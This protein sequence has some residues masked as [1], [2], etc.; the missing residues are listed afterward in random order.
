MSTFDIN[1]KNDITLQLNRKEEGFVKLFLFSNFSINVEK[2]WFL[3]LG[4]NISPIIDKKGSIFK[5][6]GIPMIPAS[7]FKGAIRSKMEWLLIN[8]Q[9]ELRDLFNIPNDEEYK[10]ILKPCIPDAH[11]TKAE[12]EL[13]GNKYRWNN[14]EVQVDENRINFSK[15]DRGNKLGICPVCYFMGAAGLIGFVRVP[16]LTAVDPDCIVDQTCIRIDRK[17]ENATRGAKVDVESVK[18][19]TV[20]SG[21]IEIIE[22]NPQGFVFGQPRKIGGIVID[23][24]LENWEVKDPKNRKE[25]LFQEIFIPTLDNIKMLGGHKSKGAGKVNITFPVI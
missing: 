23:K 22:E 17:T 1:L 5:V 16:N 14:C 12:Q 10:D 20:F 9:K 11:P 7:S 15:K 8:K 2:D 13:R 19:V 18:P 3:H 21:T 24:W 6:D 4:A 25:I